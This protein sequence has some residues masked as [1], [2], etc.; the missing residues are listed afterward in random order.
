MILLGPYRELGTNKGRVTL[1]ASGATTKH[2]DINGSFL[3]MFLVDMQQFFCKL[4]I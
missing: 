2:L 4:E 3:L 1:V